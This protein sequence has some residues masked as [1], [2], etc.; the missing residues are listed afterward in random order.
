MKR[1]TIL[2]IKHLRTRF[3]LCVT[4]L[5]SAVSI[6]PS[7][8]QTSKTPTPPFGE[9]AINVFLTAELLSLDQQYELAAT[10]LWPLAR[11]IKDPE[12][13]ERMVQWGMQAKR[14][15]IALA[16]IAQWETS[17][18]NAA[19]PQQLGDGILLTTERYAPFT[20]R[21]VQRY[22]QLPKP[23]TDADLIYLQRLGRALNLND[24]QRLALYKA[25]LEGLKT[26]EDQGA[27]QYTFA[28][29]AYQ[30]KLAKEGQSHM[31]AASLAQPSSAQAIGALLQDDPA[32]ATLS[33]IHWTQRDPS[34]VEAWRTLGLVHARLQNTLPAIE[35]FNQGLKIAPSDVSLLL[36]RS[37]QLRFAKQANA[38]RDS[39][40]A[41]HAAKSSLKSTALA[42]ILA[43][44]LEDDYFFMQALEVYALAVELASDPDDQVLATAKQLSL[45]A[46]RGD[47]ASLAR[48]L[49]SQSD[50]RGEV[51]DAV[52]KIALTA[53]REL[54]EFEPALRL[55]D[56]LPN[57]DRVYEQALTFELMGKHQQAETLLRQALRETPNAPHL[58]NLLGYGLV[59]RNASPAAL[60]EGTQLLEAALAAS[61]NSAAI[62]DSLGW[63]YFRAKQ[64]TQALPLL[65]TAYD[66]KRDPEVAAHLGE[67]FWVTGDT[68]LARKIWNE[69][70]AIDP[71]HKIL[72]STLKRFN[73]HIKP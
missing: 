60:Q 72:T 46:R 65:Q 58:L 48:L 41:A 68:V 35:A 69:G 44:Q 33:A 11:F 21:L 40:L 4:I 32:Q 1:L 10:T 12:L 18:P 31:R 62:M 14:V 54:N 53:L 3:V 49:K 9:N 71:K 55:I 59:E 56:T 20:N 13:F 52:T 36:E 5:V 73:I 27:V 61:P 47:S 2:L 39:L 15:D 70:V 42:R 66:L 19:K 64:Y 24:S 29:L 45:N 38:A 67:L 43:E 17:T 26:H 51:Q 28:V 16:A 50:T 22:Q 63:A 30:A 57:T 8:A 25:V 37:E 23:L 34:N 7:L 6:N